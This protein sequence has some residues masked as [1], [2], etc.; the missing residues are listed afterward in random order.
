MEMFFNVLP[1]YLSSNVSVK[2]FSLT[3]YLGQIS[4]S[5]RCFNAAMCS[6]Y[7]N[8]TLLDRGGSGGEGGINR[9]AALPCTVESTRMERR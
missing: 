9:V 5:A 3:E 6:F 2:G 8:W 1:V 7:Y 4:V